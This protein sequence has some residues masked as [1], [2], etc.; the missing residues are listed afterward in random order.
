[1]SEVKEAAKAVFPPEHPSHKRPVG[2]D[3]KK[4]QKFDKSE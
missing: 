2:T 3:K 4:G 1:M